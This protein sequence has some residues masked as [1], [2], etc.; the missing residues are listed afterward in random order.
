MAH[1]HSFLALVI[2]VATLAL[3]GADVG[4][5][6]ATPSGSGLGTADAALGWLDNHGFVVGAPTT[7]AGLTTVTATRAGATP[8][9]QDTICRLVMSGNG[10]ASAMLQIDLSD[11]S[12]G[13]L[14]VAWTGEF[15]ASGLG[16]LALALSA[17]PTGGEPRAVDLGDRSMSV[18]VS[19]VDGSSQV[20]VTVEEIATGPASDGPLPVP[21]SSPLAGSFYREL[22]AG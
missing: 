10:L 14:L 8:S 5:Q 12:A 16:F 4:A 20:A 2:L 17:G 7:S 11:R 18:S 15:G 3:G 13:D 21:G 1:R 9:D 22:A 19:P 6:D